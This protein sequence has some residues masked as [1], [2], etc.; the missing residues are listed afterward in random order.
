[1]ARN[2]IG[3][4]ISLKDVSERQ[5]ISIK[6]LEQIVTHLIKS[7]LLL[8]SRGPQGGYML[9]RSPDKYTVGEI[10]RVIEG[11]LA[12]VACL[13]TPIN[14]CDRVEICP[15]IDFWKGLHKVINDYVDSVTLE[16]LADAQYKGSGCE[17]NI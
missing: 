12:P 17:Y 2:N 13:D 6:Y 14:Q 16:N 9:A 1:M 3:E 4:W 10:L 7:G 15:T 5:D 11:S 8:S